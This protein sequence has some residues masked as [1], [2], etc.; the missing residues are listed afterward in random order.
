MV[1]EQLDTYILKRRT[2]L[3][4]STQ[5]LFL[6][7]SRQKHKSPNYKASREYRRKF[8]QLLHHRTSLDTKNIK[9]KILQ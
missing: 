9:H 4:H 7:G 5:E 8:M 6:N 1:V 3:T 2:M